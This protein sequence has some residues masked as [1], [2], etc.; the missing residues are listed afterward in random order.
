MR[1]TGA[2][3]AKKSIETIDCA[4]LQ[5]VLKSD[6]D[7]ILDKISSYIYPIL[8]IFVAFWSE[9]FSGQAHRESALKISPENEIAYFSKPLIFDFGVTKSAALNL[10]LLLKV[11]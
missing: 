10:E 5:A 4:A 3:G 6:C 7:H 8:T 2:L 9:K 1:R 11:F